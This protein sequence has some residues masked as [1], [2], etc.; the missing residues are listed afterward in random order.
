MVRKKMHREESTMNA[1]QQPREHDQSIWLSN[2][3]G[4]DL[5]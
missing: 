3:P 2:L 5:K 4:K 1:T